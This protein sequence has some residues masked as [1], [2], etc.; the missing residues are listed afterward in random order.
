[1]AKDDKKKEEG[2]KS[3]GG[4]KKILLIVGP[5]LVLVVAA[6]AF[7]QFA[8]P[9]NEA[10]GSES[11]VPAEAVDK[12]AEW[13]EATHRLEELFTNVAE[14]NGKR[15]LK[16]GVTLEFRAAKPAEEIARFTENAT[17]IKDRLLILFSAKSLDDVDGAESKRLIKTEILEA[18]NDLLY[19]KPEHEGR[20]EQVYYYEFLVQ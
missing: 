18:L 7:V 2:E 13:E 15:F 10:A 16:V 11:E 4:I 9:S 20:I 19:S 3:G 1:M 8:V 6:F 17:L 12:S 14:T 5:V